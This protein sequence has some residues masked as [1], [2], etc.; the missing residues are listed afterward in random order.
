MLPLL[1]LACA[2]ARAVVTTVDFDGLTAGDIANN[3]P[4]VIGFSLTYGVLEPVLDSFGDPIP[5]SDHWVTDIAYG[6]ATVAN[7]ALAGYGAAPTGTLALDASLQSVLLTFSGLV[8]LNSFQFTLDNDTF[9]SDLFT[10]NFYGPG[11]T[12][13]SSVPVLQTSSGSV[14]SVSGLAGVSYAV[15]PSGAMYDHFVVDFAPVPEPSAVMLM[16]GAL[17]PLLRRRR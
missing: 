6:S 5:G 7:T 3:D 11:D 15:L 4:A 17:V 2:P 1:A 8:N 16:L 13:L 9:G 10:A 14:V 12:L